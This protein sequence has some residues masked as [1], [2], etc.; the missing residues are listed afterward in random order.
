MATPQTDACKRAAALLGWVWSSAHHGLINENHRKQGMGWDS[1]RVADD[2]IDAC[3][4]SGLES[5]PEVE[6]FL[7]TWEA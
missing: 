4:I 2:V 5:I 6:E 3:D 1:Y 7:R